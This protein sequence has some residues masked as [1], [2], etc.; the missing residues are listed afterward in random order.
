MEQTKVCRHGVIWCQ[1]PAVWQPVR[2]THEYYITGS[3]PIFRTNLCVRITINA[4]LA[5]AFWTPCF[6]RRLFSS[7][8]TLCSHWFGESHC[9]FILF[10]TGPVYGYDIHVCHVERGL[11]C[12]ELVARSRG[13]DTILT[14]GLYQYL[15]PSTLLQ[16]CDERS[17][18]EWFVSI[19]KETGGRCGRWS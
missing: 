8:F 12:S 11:I 18:W 7:K 1:G 5:F 16:R 13:C 10:L 2:T 3:S 14:V 9:C 17:E 19:S 6:S 4:R 15:W